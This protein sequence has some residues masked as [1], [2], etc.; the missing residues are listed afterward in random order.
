MVSSNFCMSAT[1]ESLLRII[2]PLVGR[3]DGLD[4]SKYRFPC[5]IDHLN[6][7]CLLAIG[8]KDENCE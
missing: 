8:E 4:N 5:F 2:L 1:S 3:A 6:R 7:L